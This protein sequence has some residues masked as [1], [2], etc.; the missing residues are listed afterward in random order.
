MV[1]GKCPDHGVA[2]IE[3]EEENYF[4]RLSKYAEQLVKYIDESS[5]VLPAHKNNELRNF[6]A[7][8]EDISISRSRANLPR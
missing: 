7:K 6:V 4:F 1:D 3:Y 2:P 8:M 5:F